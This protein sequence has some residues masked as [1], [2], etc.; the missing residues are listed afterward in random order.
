M[1]SL[2]ALVALPLVMVVG[3]CSFSRD[4]IRS[5]EVS[6]VDTIE[7]GRRKNPEAAAGRNL[8]VAVAGLRRDNG[9]Y[10]LRSPAIA[11]D[12]REMVSVKKS[13][14]VRTE[15][16]ATA[17]VYG[18]LV[19]GVLLSG[20]AAALGASA[21][22]KEDYTS[23]AGAY[24]PHDAAV[25]N[26]IWL[27]VP[28]VIFLSTGTFGLVRAVDDPWRLSGETDDLHD[29][30]W[31]TCTAP[32]ATVR[33]RV[34]VAGAGLALTR[35]GADWVVERSRLDA[36]PSLTRAW[37]VE[38]TA[39]DAR[40]TSEAP[41]PVWVTELLRLYVADEVAAAAKAGDLARFKRLTQR[42]GG[43]TFEGP[44][45]A[46]YVAAV[47]SQGQL[48]LLLAAADGNV[49]DENARRLLAAAEKPLRASDSVADWGLAIGVWSRH[50]SFR[51]G[52]DT[53]AAL[54]A[55]FR[56]SKSLTLGLYA[57]KLFGKAPAVGPELRALLAELFTGSLESAAARGATQPLH[58][59]LAEAAALL[60]RDSEWALFR[61]AHPGMIAFGTLAAQPA[62]AGSWYDF[63]YANPGSPYAVTAAANFA[64]AVSDLS[65]AVDWL[66]LLSIGGPD[67][68]ARASKALLRYPV[69]EVPPE[70]FVAGLEAFGHPAASAPYQTAVAWFSTLVNADTAAAGL[71]AWAAANTLREPLEGQRQ[72]A[73]T[74]ASLEGPGYASVTSR[75]GG[76]A[77]RERLVWLGRVS[78]LAAAVDRTLP[79]EIFSLAMLYR[80]SAAPC[81]GMPAG[82]AKTCKG[83]VDAFRRLATSAIGKV[84]LTVQFAA[85]TAFDE[86]GGGGYLLRPAQSGSLLCSERRNCLTGVGNFDS[87]FLFATPVKVERSATKVPM[88]YDVRARLVG[89][90]E[91]DILADDS[92]E[93]IVNGL[94]P[95][96]KAVRVGSE[97]QGEATLAF[98][99]KNC[100]APP[101]EFVVAAGKRF[102]KLQIPNRTY[103]E[104]EPVSLSLDGVVFE[105]VR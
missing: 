47:E 105:L 38:F 26:A 74:F 80:F 100:A 67:D 41:N 28:G 24:S 92:A 96:G 4:A 77:D 86:S 27:G 14:Y 89:S 11:F 61:E 49:S 1:R 42:L 101:V 30:E 43:E 90:V 31:R 39:A 70:E 48:D 35:S 91:P 53:L 81:D 95:Q 25:G 85:L 13:S 57:V 62:Q 40:A 16:T 51:P 58:A 52:N 63:A 73:T 46:E 21:G 6:R 79:Y 102:Q 97:L 7:T 99:V 65:P 36:L 33:A 20:G 82:Q 103:C 87:P 76:A 32:P 44:L 37:S 66:R 94:F 22:R 56:A 75:D 83:N 9:T 34:R 17:G 72:L 8:T 2:T 23:T 69:N 10:V 5:R 15:R 29:G 93:L 59:Q 98:R 84:P 19:L 64:R 18:D 45:V 60:N 88:D 71:E 68:V 54:V 3:A 12:C 50:P 55:L 104:A 78:E